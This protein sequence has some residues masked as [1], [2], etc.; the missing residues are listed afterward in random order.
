MEIIC[1]SDTNFS[2][3]HMFI[4]I[5]TDIPKCLQVRRIMIEFS[6]EFQIL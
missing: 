6:L 2:I 1:H 5:T 4:E 3:G